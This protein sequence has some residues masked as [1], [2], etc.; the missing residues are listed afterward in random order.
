L[1]GKERKRKEGIQ[2][3]HWGRNEGELGEVTFVIKSLF[4]SFCWNQAF[5]MLIL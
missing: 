2:G 4:S 3:R 1:E 5:E